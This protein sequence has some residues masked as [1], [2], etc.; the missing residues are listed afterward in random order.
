MTTA[1][2]H[3]CLI[4]S[5]RGAPSLSPSELADLTFVLA[6]LP[7]DELPVQVATDCYHATRRALSNRELRADTVRDLRRLATRLA[8]HV[9]QLDK[10]A[11]NG[12]VAAALERQKRRR[13]E[14]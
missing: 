10:P 14:W 2:F 4:A 7:V 9:Q 13:D 5:L 11:P 3:A 6:R 12:R 8:G 1:L